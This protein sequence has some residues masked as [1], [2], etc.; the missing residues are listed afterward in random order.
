MG[1]TIASPRGANFCT[2]NAQ[3]E[4]DIGNIEYGIACVIA[5][6]IAIHVANG[7]GNHKTHRG[8]ASYAQ[9]KGVYH[10]KDY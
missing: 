6:W 10:G 3:W 9:K 1:F 5:T 8:I 7:K 4:I 2:P